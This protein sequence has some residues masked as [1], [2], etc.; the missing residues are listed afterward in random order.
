M[1]VILIVAVLIVVLL[2]I[3]IVLLVVMM[4]CLIISTEALASTLAGEIQLK[5]GNRLGNRYKFTI[6]IEEPTEAATKA[7][8]SNV[9]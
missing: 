9:M 8:S 4:N 6:G 1:P 5:R 2:L 7:S 3:V